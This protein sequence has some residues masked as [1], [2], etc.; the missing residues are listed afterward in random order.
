MKE[1]MD[2]AA[3]RGEMDARELLKATRAWQ[4]YYAHTYA[5]RLGYR[6]T[7]PPEKETT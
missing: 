4:R 1:L 3:E 5:G 7:S 2:A 6:L